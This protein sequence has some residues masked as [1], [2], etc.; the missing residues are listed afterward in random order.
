MATVYSLE[1]Q[2]HSVEIRG[3][4]NVMH[5]IRH[6]AIRN[7]VHCILGRMVAQQAQVGGIVPFAKENRFPVVATL[8]DMMR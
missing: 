7:N 3:N 4:H 6:Q 2:M 1:Q 5:V 8:G